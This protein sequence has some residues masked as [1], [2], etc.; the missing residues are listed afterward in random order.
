MTRFLNYFSI[1]FQI[2]KQDTHRQRITNAE[3]SNNKLWEIIQTF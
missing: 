1:Y 2:S 3:N